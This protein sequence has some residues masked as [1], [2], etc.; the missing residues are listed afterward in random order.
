MPLS[1]LL[2]RQRRKIS[3]SVRT[4]CL[5][6][7]NNFQDKQRYTEKL[8]LEKPQQSNHSDIMCSYKF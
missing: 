6:L 1:P 5:D 8:N 7:Q 3:V 4:V 2:K